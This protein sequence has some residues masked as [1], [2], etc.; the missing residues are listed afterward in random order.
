MRRCFAACAMRRAC[1]DGLRPCVVCAYAWFGRECGACA[2]VRQNHTSV[3]A[4]CS[5][6]ALARVTDR[7]EGGASFKARG[8][9]CVYDCW[10]LWGCACVSVRVSCKW[11]A[12]ERTRDAE[13][14]VR[15]PGR[16]QIR[17]AP[18]RGEQRSTYMCVRRNGR[19]FKQTVASM[20]IY[21]LLQDAQEDTLYGNKYTSRCGT[22]TGRPLRSTCRRRNAA[23][24]SSR[25]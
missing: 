2:A 25:S 18:P 4:A 20:H 24:S 3:C 8:W 22:A 16:V 15:V 13:P 5:F 10:E 23:R 12:R 11:P 14:C 7:G 17:R 9:A 21:P 1:A 6:G 19:I